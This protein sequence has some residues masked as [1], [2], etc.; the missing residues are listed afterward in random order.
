MKRKVFCRESS[1][2]N[3]SVEREGGFPVSEDIQDGCLM[4]IA[5]ALEKM[6]AKKGEL[7]PI[8]SYERRISALKGVITKLKKAKET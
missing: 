6:S 2:L 4:R 1:R 5:D 8:E 3:I 7:I